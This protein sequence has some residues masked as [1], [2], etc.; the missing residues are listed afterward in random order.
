[1]S[2]MEL[3]RLELE[4]SDAVVLLRLRASAHDDLPIYQVTL[5]AAQAKQV[6]AKLIDFARE[7]E[8]NGQ[9]RA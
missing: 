2:H 7:V 1:M 8:G 3:G 4:C 9:E 6:A 5:T